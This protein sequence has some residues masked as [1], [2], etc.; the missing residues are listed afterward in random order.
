MTD[1]IEADAESKF[2]TVI[3]ADDHPMFRMAMRDLASIAVDPLSIC[4]TE[5]F[6]QTRAALRAVATGPQRS[7][8]SLIL[9]DLGMPGVLG[10]SA[11]ADLKAVQPDALIVVVTGSDDPA[12]QR[13]CR[14]NGADGFLAKSLSA[15]QLAGELRRAIGKTAPT[16]DVVF[17]GAATSSASGHMPI[18]VTGPLTRREREVLQLLS[19]GCSNPQIAE[20]L[21][22]TVSAVKMR[23]QKAYQ[24][25]GVSNRVEATRVY[26]GR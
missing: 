26:L 12:T 16:G 21:R 8:R 7:H 4:E 10:P 5:S 11:I 18:S 25:L 1:V 6:E 17:D 22:I 24:K 2:G 20:A 13:Q 14:A 3:V 19:E 23:L 9:F 15:H